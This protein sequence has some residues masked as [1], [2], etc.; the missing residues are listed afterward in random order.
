MPRTPRRWRRG[1]ASRDSN[2]R[3]DRHARQDPDGD[4]AHRCRSRRARGRGA[5]RAQ[6]RLRVGAGPRV[7]HD[8]LPCRPFRMTGRQEQDL[9]APRISDVELL[10]R[11]DPPPGNAVRVNTTRPAH[12]DRVTRTKAIEPVERP[13]VR[14]S[15]PR[16]G[17]RVTTAGTTRHG[18]PGRSAVQARADP[19]LE[20]QSRNADARRPVDRPPGRRSHDLDLRLGCA[21]RRE[22]R[23]SRVAARAAPDERKRDERPHHERREDGG[24]RLHCAKE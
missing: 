5:S 11:Q 13:R 23:L 6:P 19:G 15:V 10:R 16:D 2:G 9:V 17:D 18:P 20:V 4:R 1:T 14:R 7:H 22:R 21:R 12:V 8:A 24:A 3:G